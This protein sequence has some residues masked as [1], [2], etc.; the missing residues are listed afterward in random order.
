MKTGEGKGEDEYII[1]R[2][3][4]TIPAVNIINIY[5]TQESR[6]S[7]D[8]VENSWYRMMKDV[9]EIEERNEAVIIIG[10]MNRSV[11]NDEYGIKGNKNKI[12]HGGQL[13]RNMIQGGLYIL[14]NNIDIVKGGPWT[15]VD[16]QDSNRKSCLDLAIISVSLV[17]YINK[18]EIDSDKKFT[19]RRVTK[20]KKEIKSTYTDHFSL[21]IELKNIP[22]KVH[23]EK[24]PPNWNLNKPGGWLS[25]EHLTNED[26]QKI[27]DTIE[28]EKDIN[29]VVSKINTIDTKIKFRAFGKAKVCIKKVPK[30]RVCKKSCNKATCDDCKSQSKR[31]EELIKK[32][33]EHI[34]KVVAKIK[35]SKQGR[36]GS[37][38]KM[39]KEIAG[40]KKISQET[41]A[42]RD[43]NTG[44]LLVNKEEIK[45]ATLKYCVENL[46]NNTPD[47]DIEDTVKKRKE[48]QL[49]IMKDKSGEGFEVSKE[50]FEIVLSK[51]ASKETKTYDFLLKAGNKY[52]ESM[53]SLCKRIIENEEVPEIFQNTVLIMIWKRKGSMEILKNNRFL[54]MKDVLARCVDAL[55]VR[56]MKEALITRLS[57]YQVGGLPGHS[58]LEHLLTLKTVLARMEEIGSGLIFLA[59]DIISFFDKEDIFDCLNTLEQLDVNKKAVRLWYMLNKNTKISVKTAHG[60]TH[61]ADVGDCLGQ[62]TAGAGLVSAANLDLGL[63]KHFNRS[64]KVMYFGNV[65]LQPLCYQDDVGTMCANIDMAKNQAERLSKILKEKTLQAHPDKSGI[66][67]LGSKQYKEKVRSEMKDNQI[68]LN[69][70]ALKSKL[71]DKYLGQIFE[72][73]LSS[74]ALATVRSR[75]G[76]IKGAAIE[77]K[78]II[79]DY[80]MQAMGGLMAAW[81]LWERALIPSLLAGAGTWL[82]NISETE[83]LCNQIQN[84]Y[85]RVVLKI[86]DSCPKLSLKCEPNMVDSKW[87]IW[88]EKCLLLTQIKALPD[89]SLAKITYMEAESRGWPGLGREVRQI[90]QEIGIPDIN[91]HLVRKKDI[92]K[93]I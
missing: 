37:I 55:V 66:L 59:M 36:A 78:S 46:Q 85:W 29:T 19:P 23:K 32:R 21:K 18:V 1:T 86:S 75:E 26:A 10:D 58:T 89:G 81:E 61:E 50:E 65:R 5:G 88:E 70:F 91:C 3:D 92:Q 20:T 9:T 54:H 79:E 14:I 49:K 57:I 80:Q 68:C 41:S 84:Y 72:S 60:I 87:R 12:S 11:G 74:S 90:C 24:P 28:K 25:F 52:K 76:K 82:G 7:K 93:A 40:P 39:K 67:I 77:I 8:E 43:P 47:K 15:W 30:V 53:Y 42:I 83:K 2:F 48:R 22:K 31:D 38:F 4:N 69:N 63:Q 13:I 33:T 16:R 34:E 71:S 51:F 64:N 27:K 44:E 17:P 6:T 35:E 62:G 73:D 56:Q 45:K